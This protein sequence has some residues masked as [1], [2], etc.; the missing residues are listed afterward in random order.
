[1]NITDTF[2]ASFFGPGF[3]L[4]VEA[5]Q[6]NKTTDDF[7]VDLHRCFGQNADLVR[8]MWASTAEVFRA[9]A[10]QRLHR[11]QHVS[12]EKEDEDLKKTLTYDAGREWKS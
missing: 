10:Q 3:S 12:H 2:L 6:G 5:L 7:R 4:H 11:R 1:M 8:K 9:Q